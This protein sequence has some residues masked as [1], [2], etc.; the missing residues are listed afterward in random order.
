MSHKHLAVHHKHRLDRN[1]KSRF[2]IVCTETSIYEKCK[3][4]L[5]LAGSNP[6]NIAF[7]ATKWN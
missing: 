4:V 5:S 6:L 3:K 1:V 2:K 7:N